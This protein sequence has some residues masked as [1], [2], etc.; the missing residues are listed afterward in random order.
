MEAPIITLSETEL[1]NIESI[2]E[3]KYINTFNEKEKKAYEIAKEHLG[4]SFQINKS[5]GYLEWLKTEK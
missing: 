3:T 1:I 5:I 4:M 2:N